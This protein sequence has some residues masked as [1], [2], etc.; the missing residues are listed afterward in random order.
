MRRTAAAT[1]TRKLQTP[2]RRTPNRRQALLNRLAGIRL[3]EQA[4]WAYTN[5][6]RN[7]NALARHRKRALKYSVARRRG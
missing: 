1:L 5:A 6:L 7:A 4:A 3:I 2:V